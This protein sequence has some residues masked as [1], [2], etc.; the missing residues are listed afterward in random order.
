MYIPR[1]NSPN[2]NIE[3][4]YSNS[5]ALLQFDLKLERCKPHKATGHP[6]KC[7]VIND[8][9]LFPTCDILLQIFYFI[10]LDV[11]LQTQVH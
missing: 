7:D 6:T 3:Y 5:N 10:Q 8:V 4:G 11:L 9:K 1:Y 2:E